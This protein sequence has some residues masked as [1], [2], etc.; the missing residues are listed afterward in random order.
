MKPTASAPPC[1]SNQP[2]LA[3]LALDALSPSE[4]RE[5]RAHLE[6]CPGCQRYWEEMTGL[7]RE[8]QHAGE[9]LPDAQAGES[10]H[11]ELRH[12]MRAEPSQPGFLAGSR[13]A[14]FA[15]P[16]ALAAAACV[17]V[18]LLWFRPPPDPGS[19][20]AQPAQP[21]PAT[22]PAALTW[23]GYHRLAN[24]SL[25]ALDEMMNRQALQTASANPAPAIYALSRREVEE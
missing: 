18:A 12:R 15:I 17:T 1:A 24:S 3:E 20:Q 13:L 9:T 23:W 21:I 5:L 6:R 19:S 11:R 25:D 10:F 7:C 2:R 16:A 8:L 4:T 22:A 14:R